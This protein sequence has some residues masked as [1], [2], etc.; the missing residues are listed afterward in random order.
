MCGTMQFRSPPLRHAL[1]ADAEPTKA[2]PS[3]PPRTEPG[4][5]DH[6]WCEMPE[7]ESDKRPEQSAQR[8]VR[9]RFE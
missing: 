6:L 3:E 7:G 1:I 2:A 8:V 5:Q 4:R 9:E